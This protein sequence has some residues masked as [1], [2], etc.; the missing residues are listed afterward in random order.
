MTLT[1]LG[2]TALC[3]E[4]QW[5]PLQ[6]WTKFTFERVFLLKELQFKNIFVFRME[7]D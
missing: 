3:I 4:N 6:K 5:K 1:M 7:K 2:T